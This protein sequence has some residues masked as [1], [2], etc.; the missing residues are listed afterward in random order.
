MLLV[1]LGI[2]TGTPY[3]HYLD[4]VS[5]TLY[6][7]LILHKIQCGITDVARMLH[8]LWT[9]W[10]RHKT[11]HHY[12]SHKLENLSATRLVNWKGQHFWPIKIAD[13]SLSNCLSLQNAT[14]PRLT[15]QASATLPW[16]ITW[17]PATLPWPTTWAQATRYS[18]IKKVLRKTKGKGQRCGP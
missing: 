8:A 7:P 6:S 4:S 17:A 1:Y 14:L 18:M 12:I 10:R 9:A 15:M 13:A 2:S 16:P 5:K 3:I 11:R